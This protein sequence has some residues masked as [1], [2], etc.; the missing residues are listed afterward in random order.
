MSGVRGLFQIGQGLVAVIGLVLAHTADGAQTPSSGR[1]D[2]IIGGKLSVPSCGLLMAPHAIYPNWVGKD[3]EGEARIGADGVRH[4]AI[5]LFDASLGSVEIPVALKYWLENGWVRSLAEFVPARD[6]KLNQIGMEAKL[7][8]DV[9]AGGS[10]EVDGKTRP[11][12][13]ALGE[14]NVY[15]GDA[16]DLHFRDG[17]GR[18]LLRVRL[19]ASSVVML[20]DARRWGGSE[21]TFRFSVPGHWGGKLCRGGRP[22]RLGFALTDGTDLRLGGGEPI[23]VREG[24]DWIR[25]EPMAPIAAGSALDLSAQRPTGAPTGRY[26]RVVVKGGHFEF[27]GLP[28]VRQRFWGV[29]VNGQACVLEP[30]EAERFAAELAREGYNAVRV[31][32][33]ESWLV[34]K[35]GTALDP[36]K[37]AKFDT[38]MAA[39]ARH[40]LYVTTDLFVSRRPIAW[41]TVG[42]DRDGEMTAAEFKDLVQFHD[43]VF[44]NYLAFAKA[45][46]GHENAR[47]G[48]SYA[49]DPTIVS[50]SLVNEGTVGN[51]G[52]ATLSRFREIVL[53]RYAAWLKAKQASDPETW[54]GLEAKLPPSLRGEG[55][56]RETNAFLA[57]LQESEQAFDRRVVRVL[58]EELGCRAP[59]S[60]MNCWFFP[61]QDQ[62]PRAKTLDYVDDHWYVDH[63]ETLKP[64]K[65]P[66]PAYCHN[67]NPTGGENRGFFRCAFHRVYGKPFTLTEWNFCAP[68]KYRGFGQLS[69]ATQA[70]LQD[71]GGLWCF[72]WTHGM[73]RMFAG[74]VCAGFDLDGDPI[75]LAGQRAGLF[76]FVRGD[77]PTLRARAEVVFPERLLMTPQESVPECNVMWP[78]LGWY[79][80][81]GTSV[82][83]TPSAD[84]A[85]S[86][87]HPSAQGLTLPEVMRAALGTDGTAPT[88]AG[89]GTVRFLS[90][91]QGMT[92]AT[93]RFAAGFVAEGAFAAGALTATVSGGP[94]TV[95]AASL[96]G[97][98]LAESARIL[99]THLTDVQNTEEKFA[100]P[101]FSYCLDYGRLPHLMR[102][103]RAEVAL[104]LAPGAWRVVSLA[105][106]GEARGEL[107]VRT[108]GGAVAFTAHVGR[109]PARA[110]YLYLLERR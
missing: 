23:V 94:A 58:R 109:D 45:F 41:R 21:F 55:G 14:T 6:V 79:R 47:T 63:P 5:T 75:K 22:L 104:K 107:P 9:F 11:M 92:V 30:D 25:V 95:W 106:T 105:C 15:V 1:A 54:K 8:V 3:A 87:F 65:H 97:R 43:G 103:G 71:W 44:S 61:A 91:Q 57:F 108:D 59:V 49:K 13:T 37:M 99:V 69:A 27:E 84:A 83:E 2:V 78:G 96:D 42:I 62:V 18:T 50:L 34:G 70:A 20:Q 86:A 98:P 101:N 40:G 68:G 10:V 77:V 51:F 28:G 38:L 74:K 31:H 76:A 88:E 16:K 110:T 82:G 17:N 53:P 81:I 72:A 67:A 64:A 19:D 100:E 33:H 66:P 73:R 12:P 32:H 102:N 52:L 29:N 93:S 26:G 39:F 35:D 36:Q 24:P 89:D 48:L 4:L 46:L 90:A 7:P 60:N 80:Q 56:G 85:W